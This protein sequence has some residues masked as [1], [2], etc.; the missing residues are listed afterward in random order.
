MTAFKIGAQPSRTCLPAPA[1]PQYRRAG[2]VWADRFAS[3]L[4]IRARV[5]FCESTFDHFG[6][7]ARCS[8]GVQA[9]VFFRRV[10]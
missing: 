3:E 5:P 8:S 10:P 1:L 2:T 4:R 9:D 7:G 6:N